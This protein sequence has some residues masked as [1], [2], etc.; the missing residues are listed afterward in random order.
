MQIQLPRPGLFPVSL[1]VVVA[2][3]GRE[4]AFS[5]AAL[6]KNASVT[7]TGRVCRITGPP[8]S[9]SHWGLFD[10]VRCYVFLHRI[11]AESFAEEAASELSL[12]VF[13][14]LFFL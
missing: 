7:G 13:L 5:L 1:V 12:R 6:A 14:P 10:S 3:D 8:P 9:D 4:E 2:D 11:I